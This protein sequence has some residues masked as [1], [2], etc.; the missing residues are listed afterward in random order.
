MAVE[1][2]V[3]SVTLNDGN[4][5]PSVGFGVY[6]ISPADTEQAVR[7]AVEVNFYGVLTGCRLNGLIP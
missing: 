7:T 5:I 2:N 1:G 3:R 4:S 6:Q